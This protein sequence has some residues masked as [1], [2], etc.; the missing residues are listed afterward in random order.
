MFRNSQPV[1]EWDFYQQANQFYRDEGAKEQSFKTISAVGPHSSIMHFSS[2]SDEIIAQ[3]DDLMLLD[4]GGYYESGL[5]TDCTRTFIADEKAEASEKQR[6]IYTL[7]LKGLVQAASSVVP[8]GTKGSVIDSLARAPLYKYGFDYNHGTGHGVGVHVHEPG[9][10]LHLHS[11]QPLIAGH[12]LSIEPGIYIPGFG[13]V[14]LENIYVV[15][16][17]P[18]LEGFLY[19]ESLV[20]LGFDHKLIEKDLLN[21]EELLFIQTYEKQCEERG[22]TFQ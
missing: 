10:R 3:A 21:E 9:T 7:V 15:K 8:K 2:P 17:H 22:R 18:D 4:S 19:F 14:R 1:S 6:L 16:D 11:D 20:Y 5:A 12:V 13:G